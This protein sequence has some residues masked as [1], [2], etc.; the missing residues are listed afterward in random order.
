MNLRVVFYPEGDVWLA[1]C[2]E[3]DLIGDGPTKESALES[4]KKTTEI[5]L[6]FALNDDDPANENLRNLFT[7]A[8]SRVIALYESG[9]DV[10]QMGVEATRTREYS[11]GR[12]RPEIRAVFY[13][14]WLRNK[15]GYR[16]LTGR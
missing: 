10:A 11:S 2:L 14:R 3:T 4:L 12:A 15:P 6:E 1:H 5:Q 16:L 9:G 13:S 8:T 7:P